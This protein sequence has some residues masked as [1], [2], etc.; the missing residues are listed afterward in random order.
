[1][2]LS[3]VFCVS[4]MGFAELCPRAVVRHGPRTPSGPGHTWVAS[5]AAMGD[6]AEPLAPSAGPSRE[7]LA[8]CA[9]PGCPEPRGDGGR[10]PQRR[11]HSSGCDTNKD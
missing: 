6:L 11:L 4:G 2:A 1:M 5:G 10:Q 7:H 8:R 3:Q 9:G